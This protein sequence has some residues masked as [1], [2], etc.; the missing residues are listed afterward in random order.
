M[1]NDSTEDVW[2]ENIRSTLRRGRKRANMSQGEVAQ[3][4]TDQLGTTFYQSTIGRIE[5][6]T[7]SLGIAEAVAYA[8]AIG[9]DIGHVLGS[10]DTNPKTKLGAIQRDIEKVNKELDTL[11]EKFS[12]LATDAIKS[13]IERDVDDPSIKTDQKLILSQVSRYIDRLGQGLS[14]DISV[15]TL[16]VQAVRLRPNSSPLVD[17][18]GIPSDEYGEFLKRTAHFDSMFLENDE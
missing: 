11:L 4:M 14:Y 7:R 12:K 8:R 3:S 10:V 16:I 13:A 2:L 15:Y 18:Y 17:I 6:G 5:N 1:E 9:I